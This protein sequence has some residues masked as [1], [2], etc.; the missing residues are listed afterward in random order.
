M[1]N[2]DNCKTGIEYVE[3]R[4]K[5][6]TNLLIGLLK[7]ENE[8]EGATIVASLIPLQALIDSAISKSKDPSLVRSILLDET[9]P[10]IDYIDEAIGA[11][12]KVQGKNDQT[13]KGNG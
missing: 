10:Y 4:V 11:Y 7:G 13:N 1:R 3:E 2:V 9:V 12:I 8:L 5:L 6:S